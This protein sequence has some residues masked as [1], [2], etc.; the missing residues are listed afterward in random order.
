MDA[1][2]SLQLV[3]DADRFVT[4]MRSYLIDK[5]VLETEEK[6]SS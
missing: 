4:R 3:E 5:G 6:G 2:S 1:E